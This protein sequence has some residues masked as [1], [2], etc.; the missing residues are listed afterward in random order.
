MATHDGGANIGYGLK[1]RRWPRVRNEARVAEMLRLLK[2][3]GLGGRDVTQ[4]S[5]GQRLCTASLPRRR[6]EVGGH[7]TIRKKKGASDEA[8]CA[9]DGRIAL[10][11]PGER[12]TV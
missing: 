5:D 6:R 8:A 7:R 10:A 1:L 9:A 3:D 2:L 4:L 12:I 11:V